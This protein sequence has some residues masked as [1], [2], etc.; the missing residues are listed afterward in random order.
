MYLEKDNLFTAPKFEIKKFTHREIHES[1]GKGITNV[2]EYSYN[3]N[4]FGLNTINLESKSFL[5]IFLGQFF[6]PL[7]LYQVYSIADWFNSGYI[8]FAIIVLV[9]I[10]TILFINSTKTYY[11]FLK[12]LSFSLTL[13]ARINRYLV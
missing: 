1:F 7:Y 13:K 3:L 8:S 2:R 5:N 11:N 12:I 10:I 6:T 9:L 4:R